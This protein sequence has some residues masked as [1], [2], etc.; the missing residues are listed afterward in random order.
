MT[1]R[2]IEFTHNG[3]SHAVGS[4]KTGD[5]F[6]GDAEICRHFVEDARAANYVEI[7]KT[8]PDGSAGTDETGTEGAG[9]SE[10]GTEGAGNS[11]TGTEGAGNSETGT[12]GAGNSETGTEGAGNSETGTEGAGK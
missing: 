6:T 10:T 3:H 12:E 4:F 8:Q 7:P 11:E 1:Q 2:T 9:N 5:L